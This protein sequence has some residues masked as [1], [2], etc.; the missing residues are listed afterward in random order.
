[1]SSPTT[2]DRQPQ[3]GIG[4]RMFSTVSRARRLAVRTEGQTMP[5]YGIVLAVLTSVT[6]LLFAVLGNKVVDVV[7]SVAG[8]LP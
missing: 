4:R 2:H 3:T 1:M 7:N 5:E 6:A 8:L